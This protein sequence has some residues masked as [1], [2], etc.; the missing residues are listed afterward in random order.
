[1][2]YD[3][4]IDILNTEATALTPFSATE[5]LKIAQRMR[6]TNSVYRILRG[7]HGMSPSQ[8]S[9]FKP[10][11]KENRHKAIKKLFLSIK[12]N[13]LFQQYNIPVIHL[14]GLPLSQK[15]FGDPLL[16]Q[17][18]DIDLF[19]PPQYVEQ[20]DEIFFENGIIRDKY[21]Y[22]HDVNKLKKHRMLKDVSYVAEKYGI[23]IELHWRLFRWKDKF[24]QPFEFYWNNKVP[25][26]IGGKNIFYTL[27]PIDEY[28]YL[29]V[30]GANHGF[31]SLH[32]LY[33]FACYSTL[34]SQDERRRVGER[35]DSLSIQT[36]YQIATYCAERIFP[37]IYT[38]SGNAGLLPNS[39]TRKALIS[40]I[41]H[42]KITYRSKRR[43][44]RMMAN[45]FYYI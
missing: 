5:T 28:L 15:L 31:E 32:W 18:C 1:M 10:V 43:I 36:E 30:H 14:K 23:K 11:L 8:L 16:R 34:L 4:L 20:A 24:N 22:L 39:L 12:I 38:E 2:K 6:L 29:A 13:E 41:Y 9:N 37:T 21:R 3:K 42:S 27:C 44:L 7:H 40:L 35:I 17:S 33:D 45:K 26:F 25:L 19:I